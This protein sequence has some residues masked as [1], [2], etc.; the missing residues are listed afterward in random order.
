MNVLGII[1]AILLF[2]VIVIFHE[3]GHFTLAKLNGIQVD[4][5]SLGL[6]PTLFGKEFRGTKFSLKLLPFGGACMMGE[7]DTD[8]MSDGSFNS[9]SVW[10]RMSVIVAGPVFNFIM[11]LVFSIILV[12]WTGYD[13]PV[14]GGVTAGYSAE[15][16]GLQGGDRITEIN[17]SAIH[18]WREISIFNLLHQGESAEIVYERNGEKHEATLQ[19][20]MGENGYYV[21]G[22]EGTGV[23]TKANPLTAVEYGCYELRYWIKYTFS[24][25]KMLVTGQVGIKQMSGPVG[26]VNY[27]GDTVDTYAPYGFQAVLMSLMNIAILLSA[28]LGVM[29]LLPLP[30]LDGGRL[31]FLI[32]E[33]VRRKRVPPEKEGMVHFAGFVL[34]MLLMVVV[35]YNDIT[36]LFH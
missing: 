31:I 22:V 11:A 5:F 35:M 20:R 36:S 17:G 13:E 23:N 16:A 26:I 15:E 27:V 9:K 18:I 10:A 4:E 21:L 14:I 2:S 32:I 25:L 8:D 6:G 30:A 7:D 29:N 24:S 33:A 12:A 34:L 1:L 28:N 19:S 3:L